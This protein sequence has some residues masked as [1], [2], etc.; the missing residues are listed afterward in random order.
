MTGASAFILIF[1]LLLS[2]A[3]R[4]DSNSDSIVIKDATVAATSSI[5]STGLSS[6]N[7]AL[8]SV[9]SSPVP[10]V[11]PETRKPIPVV[12]IVSF[13]TRF[14]AA[15]QLIEEAT[16]RVSVTVITS[17]GRTYEAGDNG[18][19]A[20]ASVLKVPLM[21]ATLEQIRRDG[22]PLTTKE[23]ILVR[24]MITASDNLATASLWDSIGGGEGVA[25]LLESVGL[26]GID[27]ARDHQWGDSR[28]TSIMIA[29]MVA[30]LF[31]E[32]SLLTGAIRD[33][34][35]RLMRVVV[36]DQRWGASAG[37]DF[38]RDETATLAIK[39]GW[40]PAVNGWLLNS[41]AAIDIQSNDYE[42]S[43][44]HTIVVFSEGAR[45]ATKGV[46]MIELIAAAINHEIVSP[47]LVLTPQLRIFPPIPLPSVPDTVTVAPLDPTVVPVLTEEASVEPTTESVNS[48]LLMY[49]ESTTDVLVPLETGLVGRSTTNNELT[50]W[51]EVGTA[52]AA[53]L[54]AI[55]AASMSTLGWKE[56]TAPPARVLSKKNPE[57]W[58]GFSVFPARAGLQLV[59]VTISPKPSALQAL[60]GRP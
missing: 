23:R 56:I 33:E 21:I 54:H 13:E 12:P 47:A 5:S 4:A 17:D 26:T 2:A 32:T 44:V 28:S 14:P 52:D 48:D 27:Y 1:G 34:A 31:D 37:V 18:T 3:C 46:R 11:D 16:A 20:L 50:L 41:V 29:K 42:S 43:G 30:Q 51:Y 35:L 45:T 55:Y 53:A 22:R 25:S 57:R 8:S 10:S 9:S 60:E 6:S 24:E 59:R 40:Y 15:A 58:V 19:F 7:Q 49:L 38:S 36:E 39:N